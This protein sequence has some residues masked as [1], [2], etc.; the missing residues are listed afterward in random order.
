MLKFRLGKKYLFETRINNDL[1]N[2][3]INFSHHRTLNLKTKKN[4]LIKQ[5]LTEN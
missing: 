4:M 2:F 5:W 1:Y 3:S